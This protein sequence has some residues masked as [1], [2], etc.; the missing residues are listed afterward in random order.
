[1]KQFAVIVAGGSG[2]RMNTEVPKQYLP[3]NGLPVLMHTINAFHNYSQALD[4]IVVLPPK[5]IELWEELCE[6]Y[7]F[8]LPVKIAPGGETRF[9][10]VRNGL[11]RIDSDGI[12]AIHDG[13]RPL[14]NK[15]IIAASYEI[16]ALHGSAIAAVRL[17]ESI[18][19]T[20]KDQ[21]KMA[22]RSKYRIIQTPQTFQVSLIKDAYEIT[23]DPQFTDDASVL[24]KS[25]HKISL[26]EG[27]YKNI[28]ITTPEDLIIAEAF[29]KNQAKN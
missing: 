4:I 19:V 29:L 23:E 22:D 6:K 1:M 14:V 9:Q 8:N 28:K 21:T 3:V 11:A 17:K 15:E 20:D 5:D 27:S 10:S 12:V 26:F 24:E 13:V 7:E 2:S 25:G 16:A 18:R